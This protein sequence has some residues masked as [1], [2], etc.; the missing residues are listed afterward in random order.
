MPSSYCPRLT[1]ATDLLPLIREQLIAAA[2][3]HLLPASL[4]LDLLPIVDD[5]IF[6]YEFIPHREANTYLTLGCDSGGRAV[7]RKNLYCTEPPSALRVAAVNGRVLSPSQ[8]DAWH[9][10]QPRDFSFSDWASA[11]QAAWDEL[12]EL[13]PDGPRRSIAIRDDAP[14]WLDEALTIA[15]AHLAEWDPH[16][17]FCGVPD[18]AQYGFALTG[19]K[20]GWGHLVSRAP[21]MWTLR[22]ESAGNAVCEQW[23]AAAP[24]ERG[25][26]W[27]SA[28]IAGSGA[29]LPRPLLVPAISGAASR[30]R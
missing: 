21:G 29:A 1:Q 22:W 30:Q 15:C 17:E 20:G 14:R 26:A 7:L 24:A 18:E 4:S 12:A 25:I 8:L 3:H 27:A 23:A 13:F 16:I 9:R 5:G 19:A 10:I 2:T 11:A 6:G 28:G